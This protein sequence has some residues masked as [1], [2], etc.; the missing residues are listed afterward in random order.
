MTLQNS[1]EK[2]LYANKRKM[3]RAAITNKR[4]CY[5]HTLKFYECNTSQVNR[6]K[7]K[8]ST[9]GQK[10][11]HIFSQ[12]IQLHTHSNVTGTNNSLHTSLQLYEA[13][14]RLPTRHFCSKR[15]HMKGEMI[16]IVVT[17]E[18]TF[19]SSNKILWQESSTFH[20]Q[21]FSIYSPLVT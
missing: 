8:F 20:K 15:S 3:L 2:L 4:D 7:E 16:D 9:L 1:A 12:I 6:G 14:I 5:L 10:Y 17:T 18:R 13:S 19:H 21:L 11:C